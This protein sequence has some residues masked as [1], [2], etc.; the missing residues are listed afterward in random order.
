M[1]EVSDV[2]YKYKSSDDVLKDINLSVREGEVISIIRQEWLS[3]S[4]LL[5]G[6]LQE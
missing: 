5:Q 1:I 2:C 6:L 3:E 4:L